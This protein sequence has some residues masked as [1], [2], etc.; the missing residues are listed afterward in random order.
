MKN[1]LRHL[2]VGCL[3]STLVLPCPA[4]GKE[5]DQIRIVVPM[6]E[7]GSLGSNVATVLNL[8]IWRTLRRQKIGG[9]VMWTTEPLPSNSHEE[10][11]RCARNNNAQMILWGNVTSFVDK[12]LVQPFLSI[13]NYEDLRNE[14]PEN[15]TVI[16]PGG[17]APID[18]SVSL[19]RRRY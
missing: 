15:W 12:V 14:Y 6:F 4:A 7:G 9:K 18:V 3:I 11:E 19:P 10:A 1:S 17:G 16:L 2:L 8:K 13:P 5:Q